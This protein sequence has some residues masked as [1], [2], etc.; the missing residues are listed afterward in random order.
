ME[1]IRNKK[2]LLVLATILI[3]STLAAV[4]MRAQAYYSTPEH[5]RTPAFEHYH[6]RIQLVNEGEAVDFSQDKFQQEYDGSVCGA[7]LSEEPFHFHDNKDQMLHVHWNG[8]TGGELLKYYGWNFIGGSDN[9]LGE[10]YTGGVFSGSEAV[11]IHG[12]VLSSL[13]EVDRLWIY[14]GDEN[15]YVKKS[16]Q[17]F[18]NQNLEK[19]FGVQSKLKEEVSLIDWFF[20][21]VYAHTATESETFELEIDQLTRVNNLIGNIVIFVQDEE[22]SQ[23]SIAERFSNLLPL[24]DS[25]CGG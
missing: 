14:I 6:L 9:S 22:P 5:I 10:Q 16:A 1:F 15:T 13:P 24:T 4:G 21:S 11:Q 12:D 19:F 25:T 20:P 23:Q 7:D 3:V 17:D 2:S 8:M 18:I